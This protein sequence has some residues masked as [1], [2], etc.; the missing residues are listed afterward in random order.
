MVEARS[1]QPSL[2][3]RQALGHLLAAEARQLLK[4]DARHTTFRI[5]PSSILLQQ[6]LRQSVA[7]CMPGNCAQW[8]ADTLPPNQTDVKTPSRFRKNPSRFRNPPPYRDNFHDAWYSYAKDTTVS[9]FID[10]R[11]HLNLGIEFL[12]RRAASYYE[13]LRCIWVG[14]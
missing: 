10:C 9:F 5:L 12:R 4:F 14:L 13:P 2:E 8:K 7:V 11:F 3:N 1:L 6:N